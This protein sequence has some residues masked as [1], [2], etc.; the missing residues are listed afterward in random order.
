MQRVRFGVSGRREGK[1]DYFFTR[2]TGRGLYF[3]CSICVTSEITNNGFECVPTSS[4]LE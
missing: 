3:C 1:K 2:V 4:E